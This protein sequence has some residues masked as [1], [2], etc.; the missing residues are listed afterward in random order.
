MNYDELNE[1]SPSHLNVAKEALQLLPPQFMRQ[2]RVIPIQ[3]SR[4]KLRLA[5][6]DI[7]DY[8]ILDN[9]RALSGYEIEPV[10]APGRVISHAL[11][12]YLPAL[13]DKPVCKDLSID[14][15]ILTKSAGHQ[16]AE[17]Q[18]VKIVNK[19]IEIALD[20][21]A[22]DIHLEPQRKGLFARI[23]IDGVLNTIHEFPSSAQNHLISRIKIMAG[24]DISEKRLPQDGQFT[25][26]RKDQ[27]IGMRTSTIP[28]IYEEK[29]VVRIL[30]KTDLQLD[31][32]SLGLPKTL[33]PVLESI[34]ERPNGLIL[35]TGPTG[36]GKTSTLYAFLKHLLS[37]Y[38][39]LITSE[40][41]IEYE[42]LD[43]SLSDLGVT[44]IQINPKVGMT[45]AKGLP[46]L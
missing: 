20:N 15:N 19:L 26:E 35:V 11:Q 17:S 4:Q 22:S 39:N 7:H 1:P 46:Y 18:I 43:H 6:S 10:E 29:V 12:K 41:P 32:H 36:T 33:F 27:P 8:N 5:M 34:I 16:G 14:E 24:L 2:H 9:A 38:K 30:N 28:G 42:L 40:D 25:Y 3:V 21:R 13:G 37:N 44:Q 23:R 31:L 45:F